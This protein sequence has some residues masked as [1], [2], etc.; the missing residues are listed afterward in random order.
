MSGTVVLVRGL[1]AGSGVVRRLGGAA[2]GRVEVTRSVLQERLRER[3]Y[4]SDAQ[5]S[6]GGRAA[7]LMAAS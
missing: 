3:G 2:T 5:W 7:E 6:G 1:A 4:G